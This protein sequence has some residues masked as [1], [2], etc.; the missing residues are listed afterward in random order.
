MRRRNWARGTRLKRAG[1]ARHYVTAVPGWRTATWRDVESYLDGRDV[2][3]TTQRDVVSNL[4]AFYRWAGREG[5]CA[6][7]PTALVDTPKV[8][9]RLPRPARPDDIAQALVAATPRVAAMVALMAGAGLRCCEVAALTWDDVDLI[10]GT[11]RVVG[12]GDRERVVGLAPDVERRLFL[13]D[14]GP[15]PVFLNAYG[16][17]CSRAVVS[18]TVNA[19]FVELGLSARA[20]RLRHW[21]AT[22]A[23]ARD[24]SLAKVRDMLG[25]ATAATTEMYAALVPGAATDLQRATTL[26]GAP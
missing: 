5:Y 21:H 12:K 2:A 17:P 25:H 13:L 16:R 4:R 18:Q 19:L 3:P 6:A 20:H 24:G 22:D 1:E 26:P 8:P 10:A 23:L 15:G 9:R 7:D 11:A 14:T